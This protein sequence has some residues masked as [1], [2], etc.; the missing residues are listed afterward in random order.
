MIRW[1]V[2]VKRF[3]P[4]LPFFN[5][6]FRIAVNRFAGRDPQVLQLRPHRIAHLNTNNTSSWYLS[7]NQD[8]SIH[9]KAHFQTPTYSVR[10]ILFCYIMVKI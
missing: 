2:H 4:G 3:A 6:N 9:H 7:T 10:S 5:G 1:R 8:S